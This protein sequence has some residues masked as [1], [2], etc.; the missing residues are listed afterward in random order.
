M[1][2]TETGCSRCWNI[3]A[4]RIEK[5]DDGIGV[6]LATG[7]SSH[8]RAWGVKCYY[9]KWDE[10]DKVSSVMKSVVHL[11]AVEGREQQEIVELLAARIDK[12]Y[13]I[14][15]KNKS[16][17]KYLQKERKHVDRLCRGN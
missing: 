16:Q 11:W 14:H 6:C 10:A 9:V 2:H 5:E 17:K 12:A 1:V 4:Y 7:Q 13:D 15:R 3:D 8:S